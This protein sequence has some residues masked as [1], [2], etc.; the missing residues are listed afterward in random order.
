[1]NLSIRLVIFES[2]SLPQAYKALEELSEKGLEPL[3]FYP[4]AMGARILFKARPEFQEVLPQDTVEIRITEKILKALLSQSGNTLL[5]Y[6]VVVESKSLKDLLALAT[7]FEKAEADILEIRTLRSNPEKNYA[8]F[9]LNEKKAAEQLVGSFDH[10][11]LNS[12]SRAL[13]DFLG[14]IS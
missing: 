9:T 12:S 2:K 8:L 1:M 10:A 5:K 7:S 14:F 4:H 6:L 13:S 11:F 3:E